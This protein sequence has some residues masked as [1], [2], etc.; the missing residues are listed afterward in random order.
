[1]ATL[2]KPLVLHTVPTPNGVPIS[3]FLEELKVINP[4]PTVDYDVVKISF[5]DNDQKKPPFIE[6][7]PNGRIPVLTDRSRGNFHVFE[8]SAILLYL[9]QHYDKGHVF[10]F[11]AEEDPNDYSE[12]LQWLFFAHGGIG[13]MQGQANHFGN[14]AP[15]DIPYAKKRY[16]DETKRLYGVLEIR[17]ASRDYLA[18]PAKGKYSI[19]DLKAFCW[20]R[21]CK[22]SGIDDLNAWPAVKAWVERISARPA[23][24]AGL[25]VGK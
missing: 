18:G 23:V 5:K 9:A 6:M 13:P 2:T 3:I 8:S 4:G 21:I 24:V 10:W 19:A 12:M 1:M 15:E 14:A 22:Y 25:Q 17:L 7:N 11:D 20:V 16:L